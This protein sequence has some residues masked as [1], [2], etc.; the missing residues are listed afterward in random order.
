MDQD[1][2]AAVV[3]EIPNDTSRELPH[4]LVERLTGEEKPPEELEKEIEASSSR[5]EFL[6]SAHLES[7]K[8]RAARETQR[9]E[10]ASARRRRVEAAESRRVQDKL[11]ADN[12]KHD[13]LVAQQ[14]EQRELA[15]AKREERAE[16]ANAAREAHEVEGLRKG[17]KAADRELRAVE[18]RDKVV[19]EVVKRNMDRTT[20]ALHVAATTRAMR[21]E[22]GEGSDAEMAGAV[23]SELDDKSANPPVVRTPRQT[24]DPALSTSPRRLSSA[25]SAPSASG[26]S[27]PSA[28]APTS[29]SG[30]TNMK[31]SLQGLN[32][33][34]FSSPKKVRHENRYGEAMP[35]KGLPHFEHGQ[36]TPR[37]TESPRRSEMPTIIEDAAEEAGEAWWQNMS[38]PFERAFERTYYRVQHPNGSSF[39]YCYEIRWADGTSRMVYGHPSQLR[40]LAGSACVGSID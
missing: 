40:L 33:N 14:R 8:E 35:K 23:L 3:V 38:R 31:G 37:A 19:E 9:V 6:H 17:I 7:V 15:K 11:E 5:A 13:A 18:L 30:S 29:E 27:A 21:S 36:F 20:H 4:E 28:S 26:A 32:S 10:E 34:A 16:K 39:V 1:D 25:A 2:H 12:Q 24:D 22:R